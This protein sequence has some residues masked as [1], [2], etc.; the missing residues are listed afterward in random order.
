[1]SA[2]AIPPDWYQVDAATG[3]WVWQRSV[4]GD[5]YGQLWLVGDRRPLAHRYGL[6]LDHLCR[7]RGCVNPAHLEPVTRKENVLRGVGFAAQNARKTHCPRG[8]EYDEA[9]TYLRPGRGSRHCRT[10]DREKRREQRAAMPKK[11]R[12]RQY[13]INGRKLTRAQA[14]EI[15]D[16]TGTCREVGDRFGVSESLVSMIRNGRVW[17]DAGTAEMV[18]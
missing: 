18:A 16:S 5:G 9:N 2:A 12:K 6:Q 13:V 10:C 15:R 4:R 11:P 7:N 14:E 17:Q 1:M 3:C 8:H